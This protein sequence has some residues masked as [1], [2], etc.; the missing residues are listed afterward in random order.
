MLA[1]TDPETRKRFSLI[2]ATPEAA[3]ARRQQQQHHAFAGRAGNYLR[4]LPTTAALAISDP[5]Y[6]LAT[7][8]R[9]QLPC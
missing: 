4:S 3:Q 7:R 2:G 8:L 1:G 9:L 6:D 5:A